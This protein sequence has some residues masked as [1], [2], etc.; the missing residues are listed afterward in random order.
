MTLSL[1]AIIRRSSLAWLLLLA[2]CV[3]ASAQTPAAEPFGEE[4]AAFEKG[5][6][7]QMPPSGAVLFIGSSTIGRWKT[8]TADFP[9]YEVINRG[10]GGSFVEHSTRYAERI[11]IPY[12]P[13]LIVFYAGGN[14]LAVGN[15][16]PEKV[17]ADYRA[18]VEKVHQ[19]LPRTRFAYISIMP[20]P[21]RSS[22][23]DKRRRANELI[24]TYTKRD[25]RLSYID[26]SLPVLTA[27]GNLRPELYVEDQLHLNEA[28][29]G[30]LR[31]VVAEHL[32]KQLKLKP[33]TKR[34]AKRTAR[35][36]VTRAERRTSIA[37][38]ASQ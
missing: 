17:A 7:V 28:G 29:Y 14:D 13:S 19:K 20:N 2:W 24:E 6:Q 21:A 5:D 15:M 4:I 30:V 33:K 31:E 11:I 25:S 35:Q 3:S 36:S 18:L 32:R 22:L 38:G 37:R 34:D 9:Q 10:F 23:D 8:L 26:A 1:K 27:N 16:T 12:K